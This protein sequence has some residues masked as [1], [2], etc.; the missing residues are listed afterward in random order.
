MNITVILKSCGKYSVIE[1]V[2]YQQIY[3]LYRGVITDVFDCC[4]S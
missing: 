1:L 3:V 2:L 4:N